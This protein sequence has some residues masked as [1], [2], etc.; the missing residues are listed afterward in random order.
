MTGKP[1]AV[2]NSDGRHDA[3]FKLVQKWLPKAA[4]LK[5]WG[6]FRRRARE[7]ETFNL[8]SKFQIPHC[9]LPPATFTFDSSFR[10]ENAGNPCC[11]LDNSAAGSSH[12]AEHK[13][14][15]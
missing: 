1:A 7:K 13:T 11:A 14:R 15:I 10:S 12:A 6:E 9:R 8:P 4:A 3:R 2:I 5:G